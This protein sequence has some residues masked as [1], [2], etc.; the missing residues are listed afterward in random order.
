MHDFT[1]AEGCVLTEA[2][3]VGE[4][5]R[6]YTMMRGEMRHRIGLFYRVMSGAARCHEP[7]TRQPQLVPEVDGRV[8]LESVGGQDL[9]DRDTVR[10]GDRSKGFAYGDDVGVVRC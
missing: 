10:R 1:E 6:R 3:E 2:V 5:V 7:R 4:L 9:C 8:A